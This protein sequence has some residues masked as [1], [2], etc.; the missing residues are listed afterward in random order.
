M[1]EVLFSQFVKRPST[2][3]LG[4]QIKVRANFFEVTRMQ[5]TNISQYEV[6]ITPT[7]P[8]RLNRRVFNRL[9]EQ[10]RERALGGARPVFDGSAIVFTHK[11][12]PF[13]TR[14]FDVKYLKFYFL[15]FLTFEIFKFNYHN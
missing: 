3:D 15:P 7:V 9:V 1:E 6:N 14:S 2:C 4:A 13:E 8:Q 5:D 12:L 11:P 10:Y